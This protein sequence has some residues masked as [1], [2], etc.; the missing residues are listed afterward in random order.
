MQGA[1]VGVSLGTGD[2]TGLMVNVAVGVPGV[3]DGAIKRVGEGGG[4]TAMIAGL[5]GDRLAK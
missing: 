4:A 2:G 1:G 3:I 5:L